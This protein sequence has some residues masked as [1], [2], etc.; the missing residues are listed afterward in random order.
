MLTQVAEKQSYKLKGYIVT[1]LEETS[2]YR[3]FPLSEEGSTEGAPRGCQRP[4]GVP[5][6]L[7]PTH[8]VVKPYEHEHGRKYSIGISLCTLTSIPR[9]G[10]IYMRHP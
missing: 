8:E 9:D 6:R 5:P 3:V 2:S 10:F 7:I 4:W 1:I